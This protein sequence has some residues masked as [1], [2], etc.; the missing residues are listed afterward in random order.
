MDF[1]RSTKKGS[2]NTAPLNEGALRGEPGGRAPLLGNPNDM[3]SKALE[4]GMLPQEPH[5]GGHGE[6]SFHT[7]YERRVKFLFIRRTFIEFKRHVTEGSGKG[8]LS[9]KRPPLLGKMEGDGLLGLLRDRCRRALEM[10]HL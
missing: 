1:E 4:I 5:F 6:C 7:A 2:G 9:S 3:S 10:E 8:Q